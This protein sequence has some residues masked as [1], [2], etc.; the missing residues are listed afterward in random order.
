M[1]KNR[2][3]YRVVARPQAR[4]RRFRA[5]AA[6]LALACLGAVAAATV[7]H[8]AGALLARARAV[9]ALAST[10]VEG[11]EPLKTLAQ[12]YADAEPGSAGAKAA[13]IRRRL[14]CLLDVRVRRRWTERSAT[15]TLVPRRPFARVAGGREPAFV[16][17]SGLLFSAPEGAF[18]LSGPA[19]EPGPA[20]R[21]E[22]VALAKEWPALAAPGAFPAELS[23]LAY[24]SDSDGWEARLADGTSV[25]WGRLEWTSEKLARLA[26]ALSDAKAK[27]PS[28]FS[29]DL[30][31][32]EDG[33]VLLKPIAV[34]PTGL[35]AGRKS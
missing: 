35:V 17:E 26:E 16:D 28:S 19:V 9:T 32:F 13:A 15:L 4:V 30:R 31:W 23:A 33:K 3:R 1:S 8:T 27:E 18:V 10:I 7:R 20:P 2:R 11:P 25:L 6:V 22:L 34:R 14:P 12:G 5:L 24:R 21:A 29:A